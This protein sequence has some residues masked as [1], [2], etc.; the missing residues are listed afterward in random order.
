MFDPERI[1]VG[2][3]FFEDKISST[4]YDKK[5]TKKWNPIRLKTLY[6]KYDIPKKSIQTLKKF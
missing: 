4:I 6:K 5:H 3:G 1:Q 2:E